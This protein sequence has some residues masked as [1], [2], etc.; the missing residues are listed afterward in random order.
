MTENIQMEELSSPVVCTLQQTT[1]SSG[2]LVATQ[3]SRPWPQSFGFRS[4]EI[5]PRI[6]FATSTNAAGLG[7]NYSLRTTEKG[8]WTQAP[9]ASALGRL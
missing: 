5:G 7:T 2:R 8:S 1:E 4:I 9:G 3:I 6:A